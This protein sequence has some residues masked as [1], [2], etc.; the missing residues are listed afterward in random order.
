MYGA[1]P[2]IWQYPGWPADIDK[3][4]AF[5]ISVKNGRQVKAKAVES[6][7]STLEKNEIL[8]PSLCPS[9]ACSTCRVKIL[10]G[11]VYQPAG[12]P[13]RKPD[14]QFGYVHSCMAFPISDLEILL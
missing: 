11:Q 8:V 2:K 14:R 6:L 12:I 13:V 4:D 1:P 9:R 7:L 10:S 3:D 5:S